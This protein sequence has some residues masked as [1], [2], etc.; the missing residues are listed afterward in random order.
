VC[1]CVRTR[2]WERERTQLKCCIYQVEKFEL[3]F[4]SIFVSDMCSSLLFILKYIEWMHCHQGMGQPQTVVE[5]WRPLG[6]GQELWIRCVNNCTHLALDGLPSW[7]LDRRLTV[8]VSY[9]I[10]WSSYDLQLLPNIH[11]SYIP[12]GLAL[13]EFCAIQN[14]VIYGQFWMYIQGSAVEIDIG[15]W[16]TA[17][18]LPCYLCYYPAV[19]FHRLCPLH[20]HSTWENL[21]LVLKG[22]FTA[23][24]IM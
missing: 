8:P 10:S 7:R 6:C 23:S 1:V 15:T 2:A 19:F 12:E 13:V 16:L 11:N 24:K 20:F 17:G 14:W 18:W 3:P 5:S 9:E 4:C 21:A 22:V